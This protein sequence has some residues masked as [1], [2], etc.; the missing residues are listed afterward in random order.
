MS[1]SGNHI[2]EVCYFPVEMVIDGA[3]A[4][5]SINKATPLLYDKVEG[6]TIIHPGGN[7]GKG[8]IQLGVAGEE[9]FPKGFHARAFMMM[10]S[11][12]HKDEIITKEI[13]KYMYTFEENAKGSTIS[14]EYIEPADGESGVMYLMFKL[15]REKPCG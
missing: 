14:A 11:S 13:D 9:I 4:K 12:H 10:H 7:H 15:T 1:C 8:T 2:T 6:V 3:K 5:V